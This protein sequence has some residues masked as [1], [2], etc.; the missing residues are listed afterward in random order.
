MHQDIFT[1]FHLNHSKLHSA[2]LAEKKNITAIRF[3]LCFCW[4][5]LMK[6]AQ[7]FTAS[8]HAPIAQSIIKKTKAHSRRWEASKSFCLN[9]WIFLNLLIEVKFKFRANNKALYSTPALKFVRS[10][11][12]ARTALI[13]CHFNTMLSKSLFYFAIDWQWISYFDRKRH[14]RNSYAYCVLNTKWYSS[15]AL[16]KVA[17]MNIL[18]NFKISTYFYVFFPFFLFFFFDFCFAKIFPN[19][20]L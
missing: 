11:M 10:F 4:C 6:S 17:K 13:V 14:Q 7:C 15:V 3:M 5:H 18:C 12:S 19:G 2:I 8:T 20:F 1:I 16:Q 9:L